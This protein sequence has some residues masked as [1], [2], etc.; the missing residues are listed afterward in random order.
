[1]DLFVVFLCFLLFWEKKTS[2]NDSIG[3]WHNYSEGV[4]HSPFQELLSVLSHFD[5][6][7]M[8]RLFVA[9]CM[10]VFVSS[11]W[12][13]AMTVIRPKEFWNKIKQ[14]FERT[15]RE[16][17]NSNITE[18]LNV[19]QHSSWIPI[20]CSIYINL[21]PTISQTMSKVIINNHWN[22]RNWLKVAFGIHLAHFVVQFGSKSLIFFFFEKNYKRIVRM[23]LCLISSCLLACNAVECVM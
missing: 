20:T 12:S 3:Q 18:N 4:L 6:Y 21:N 11:R 16:K 2:Q 10:C 9:V 13:I 19:V 15:E 14:H 8:E 7:V 1:M 5:Y 17:K 23:T 22:D